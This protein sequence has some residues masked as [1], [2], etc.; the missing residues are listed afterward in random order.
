MIRLENV[1]KTYS[2]G[3]EKVKALEDISL[4]LEEGSF[5]VLLGDSGSGK[6]TLFNILGLLTCPTGGRYLFMD[7][8]VSRMSDSGR[9]K[10]RGEKIGFVFQS[11]FLNERYTALENVA[12][13]LILSG[14]PLSQGRKKAA[15]ALERVGLKERMHHLPRELSGGQQQRVAFARA[16]VRQ[17]ELLLADEPTGNLDPAATRQV[18]DLLRE[19]NR[20]GATVFTITHDRRMAEKFPTRYWIQKGKLTQQIKEK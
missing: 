17:P 18:M 9:A 15:E 4:T 6:T 3:S 10:L 2:M 8:D 11:F 1:V 13:P 14:V 12:F 20:R 7:R 5:S 16:T 19:E